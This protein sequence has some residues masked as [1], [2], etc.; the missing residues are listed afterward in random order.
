MME[1]LKIIHFKEITLLFC[2]WLLS[3]FIMMAN[4]TPV[5]SSQNISKNISSLKLETFDIL[6]THCN[7]CHVDK[8]PDKLFSIENMDGFAKNIN[9]QVF[10][11]K[12]M[13]KGKEQREKISKEE[14]KILKNW[15]N[16]TL[17]K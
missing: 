17:G 10:V 16:E 13:P 5:M 4:V 14:F 12:R 1:R 6:D 2:L 8:N 11:F 3:D 9:R 7:S 15:I